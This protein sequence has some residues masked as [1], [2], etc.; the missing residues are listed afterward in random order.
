[1][2]RTRSKGIASPRVPTP[3]KSKKNGAIANSP[4]ASPSIKKSKSIP[5]TKSNE[6]SKVKQLQNEE[7]QGSIVSKNV[8]DKAISELSKFLDRE[9]EEEQSDKTLLFDND[10]ETKNLFLQ[11]TTKKYYSTKPNFKPKLIKLSNAIHNPESK[12]LKTCLIIRDQLI[13]DPEQLEIIENASLPTLQQIVPL[14]ALKTEYKHYEKRRQLYSEY[15]LFL[16]DDA[17][18]NSMPTLLGKVFYGNGNTKIPLPIRVTSTSNNKEF[19][20]TTIGNQLNKCLNSTFFLPPVGVNI[21]VKIGS[22]TSDFKKNQ[23][24]ENLEDVLSHFD[25]DSLRSVMIKTDLSPSLPLYYAE[26][27]YNDEDV[28]EDNT[29]V[30]KNTDDEQEVRL[31]TFEKGLL[32]LGDADEVAKI[33]GKKLKKQQQQEQQKLNKVTKPKKTK[34]ISK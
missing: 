8:A 23:L 15:D 3:T 33:I 17:L 24:V 26:K 28:L 6:K 32:E 31:S 22:I 30:S 11:I 7:V 1:M 25:K 19:S 2:A 20:I 16:V 18:L 14:S 21:S 27:L 4:A 9:A 34:S 29:K 12:S 10:E 5:K 13:T